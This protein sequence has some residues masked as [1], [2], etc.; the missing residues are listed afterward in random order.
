MNIGSA[1]DSFFSRVAAGS[2]EIY[3]ECSLQHELG[4]Y[5][6]V[7]TATA[8]YK[9]QFERPV[10]FFGLERA[11]FV[12]KEIDLTV[13]SPDQTELTAIEVKF[14]RNGQHPEQM[15]K[16]CQD[17]AFVEQLVDAG[18]DSGFFVV[19]VED[20]LFWKGPEEDGIYAHFRGRTPLHGTVVKPT[21][22]RDDTVHI[23]GS[24]TLE[25]REAGLLKYAYI[26]ANPVATHGNS[27]PS[28]QGS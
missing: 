24:Y 11:R 17:L 19:V 13:F 3:N 1:I 16:F 18:F 28:L 14:P 9:V 27:S 5:L 4:I 22:K 2:I 8:G 6:R 7:A 12:K 26:P 10:S 15:F 25:W 20:P 23:C 21:G